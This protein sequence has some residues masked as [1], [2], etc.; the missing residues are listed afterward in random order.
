MTGRAKPDPSG[1]D[2]TECDAEITPEMIEALEDAFCHWRAWN[3]DALDLGGV[4]DIYDLVL[5]LNA[6]LAKASKSS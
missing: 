4:G 3:R 6:A 1:P 5:R 2:K